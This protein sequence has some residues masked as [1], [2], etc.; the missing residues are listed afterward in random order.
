MLE[1][2][3]FADGTNFVVA[4]NETTKCYGGCHK[5]LGEDTVQPKFTVIGDVNEEEVVDFVGKVAENVERNGALMSAMKLCTEGII[6][7]NSLAV[8][9]HHVLDVYLNIIKHLIR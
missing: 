3:T 9:W 1:F 2:Y 8:S 4:G 7:L 6:I 5:L